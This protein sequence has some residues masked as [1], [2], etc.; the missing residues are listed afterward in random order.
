[1]LMHFW[2]Q[3]SKKQSL[4]ARKNFVLGHVVPG[5]LTSAKVK[6]VMSNGVS[7]EF[8]DFKVRC[9]MDVLCS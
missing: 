6:E 4:D 2:L 1:M 8:G 5:M 9:L 7:V 3:V